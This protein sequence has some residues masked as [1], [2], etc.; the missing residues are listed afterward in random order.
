[1]EDYQ[2]L[3]EAMISSY[4]SMPGAYWS[5]HHIRVLLEKFPEGQI[6]V[7]VNGAIAGCALSIIIDSKKFE[8]QHTYREIT[9]NYTFETHTEKGDI[10]YGI[11]VFVKP[12]YRGMRL[13]RRMYDYRKD[14]CERLNLRGIVFGGR[15]PN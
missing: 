13:G 1:M 7:K 9:G 15:I 12:D 10:L 4:R 11:D 8:Q 14:L 2:E 6:V 3:R 5:E